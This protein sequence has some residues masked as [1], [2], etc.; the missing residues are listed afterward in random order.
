MAIDYVYS[1]SF[2]SSLN[3]NLAPQVGLPDELRKSCLAT[4]VGGE[5]AQPVQR[6]ADERERLH[7][8]LISE[9]I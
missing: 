4:R 5:I 2:K 6:A 8:A 1:T 3:A 7:T 9:R